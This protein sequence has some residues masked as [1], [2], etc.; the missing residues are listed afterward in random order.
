ME[1]D[2]KTLGETSNPSKIIK[3]VAQ[4]DDEFDEYDDEFDM[5]N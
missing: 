1:Q 3:K 5:D 2:L 4:V